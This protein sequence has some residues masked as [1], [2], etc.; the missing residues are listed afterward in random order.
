M[1]RR[2][3]WEIS[4]EVPP[5]DV[6]YY[7]QSSTHLALGKDAP[8][9]RSVAPPSAGHIVASPEGGGLHHRYDRAA[10]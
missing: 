8:S 9:P 6:A 4:A 2:S 3:L 5:D 10:A 7:L 1:N